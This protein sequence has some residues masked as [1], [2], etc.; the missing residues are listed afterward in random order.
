[1]KLKAQRKQNEFVAVL[2]VISRYSG[3]DQKYIEAKN[4]LLGNVKT[5]YK[6]REK[7]IE[8]FENWIFPF[9]DYVQDSIFKDDN[10]NDEM[11]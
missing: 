10:E 1:M 6:G 4:K 3:R 8:D 11:K 2:S 9:E 5:F 7:I